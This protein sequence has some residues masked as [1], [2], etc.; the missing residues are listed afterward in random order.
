MSATMLYEGRKVESVNAILDTSIRGI[1]LDLST[2]P[3][4]FEIN[5][6]VVLDIVITMTSRPT[7]I[8]T[9]ARVLKITEFNRRFEVVLMYD[10]HGNEQKSMIDYVAKRQMVLIREFKG[11]QI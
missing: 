1:R 5:H 6:E 7:I 8:N 11:L 3:S 10:L 2:L 4:G 9:K